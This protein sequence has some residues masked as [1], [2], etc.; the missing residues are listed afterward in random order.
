MYQSSNGLASGNCKE[1]AISQALCELIERQNMSF[2]IEQFENLNLNLIDIE[3]IDNTIIKNLNNSLKKN[4][5]EIFLFDATLDIEVPTIVACGID[6]NLNKEDFG[7]IGYGY[8][9]HPDPYKAIIRAITE[10]I[11]LSQMTKYNN[12][13]YFKD[14]QPKYNWQ[15]TLTVNVEEKIK[16]S[17]KIKPDSLPNLSSSDFKDELKNIVD[18]LRKGNH[19]VIVINKTHP[20]INIP[21][22]RVFVPTF[23]PGTSF[24][25]SNENDDMIM[26][27]ILAQAGLHEKAQEYYEQNFKRILFD[28]SQDFLELLFNVFPDMTLDMLKKFLSPHNYPYTNFIKDCYIK[29]LHKNLSQ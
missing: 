26:L 22:Y 17:S 2:F 7:Y 29:Q 5:Y 19:E 10:Y 23:F 6:Y 11:Q 13:A 18:V 15:F 28:N 8:G 27:E 1:E 3:N 12:S 21:V 25:S 16:N 20:K 4:N 14:I 24:A 9:T